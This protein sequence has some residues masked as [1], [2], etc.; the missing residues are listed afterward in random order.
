M[1]TNER[2]KFSVA[3]AIASAASRA[4]DAIAAGAVTTRAS[5]A[6]A[7]MVSYVRTTKISVVELSAFGPK[8]ANVG[9]GLTSMI[10]GLPASAPK[11][12]ADAEYV[13]FSYPSEDSSLSSLTAGLGEA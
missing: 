10:V 12:A 6:G 8:L 13:G 1:G 2:T 7:N 3:L 4:A 11:S 5:V 9:A